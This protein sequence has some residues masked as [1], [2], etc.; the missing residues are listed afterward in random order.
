[1]PSP[2]NENDIQH[3][4]PVPTLVG[5]RTARRNT[6]DFLEADEHVPG[7]GKKRVCSEPLPL[8]NP[9]NSPYIHLYI[10]AE[11]HKRNHEILSLWVF[12]S[13][14]QINVK[15]EESTRLLSVPSN[16]YRASLVNVRGKV[17]VLDFAMGGS[18]P[19]IHQN[20]FDI[21][22]WSGRIIS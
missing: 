1:M 7:W 5:V 19:A 17:H 18:A 10:A 8:R 11:L 20:L 21:D 4:L 3:A 12:G 2:L 15:W 6:E 22:D 14:M 13:G 16:G 9:E